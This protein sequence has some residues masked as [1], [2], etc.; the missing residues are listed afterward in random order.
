[1]GVRV[2]S[3]RALDLEQARLPSQDWQ[4]IVRQS[5][6]F[7]FTSDGYWFRFQ[8]YNRSAKALPRFLEL[9]VPFLDD[10]R[11][12]H[13]VGSALQTQYSL[14]DEQPFSQRTVRHRNFVMPLQL[15]PGRNDIYLRLASSGT[16]EAPLRVWDPVQFHTASNDENLVQGAVIGMLLIMVIYNLFV[17]VSTRDINY[18]YYVG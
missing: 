16:I 14:G 2:D 4:P 3:S 15:A 17:Y 12:Y 11:L 7:G 5:P 1:M 18:L 13:F 9:P 10:V 6:N 8:L